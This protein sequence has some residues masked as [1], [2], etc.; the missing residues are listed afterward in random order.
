[1]YLL[2]S[3]RLLATC[4]NIA[5]FIAELLLSYDDDEK[6]EIIRMMINIYARAHCVE[7]ILITKQKKRA[8]YD[9]KYVNCKNQYDSSYQL[10]TRCNAWI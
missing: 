6:R 5:E 9:T 1:M 8:Y 10:Q 3:A 7:I 2:C 4:P